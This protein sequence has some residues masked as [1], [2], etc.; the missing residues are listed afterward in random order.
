VALAA[1]MVVALLLLI[2]VGRG[3]GDL[4]TQRFFYG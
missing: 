2:P 1:S 4:M 3:D